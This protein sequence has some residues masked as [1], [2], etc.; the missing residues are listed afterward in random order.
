MA[1]DQLTILRL[2]DISSWNIH[3]FEQYISSLL[4]QSRAVFFACF[5]LIFFCWYSFVLYYIHLHMS[6]R[7]ENTSVSWIIGNLSLRN[8]S[9]PAFASVC[10][11]VTLL[12][13][14][15]HFG[16]LYHAE[17]YQ[18]RRLHNISPWDRGK[19]E[20]RNDAVQVIGT[21]NNSDIMYQPVTSW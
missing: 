15:D 19:N 16:L 5:S 9:V 7:E 2:L 18:V 14:W 4:S 20:T 11:V 10:D 3:S 17:L 1:K 8:F 12:H 6:L 21:P 13:F